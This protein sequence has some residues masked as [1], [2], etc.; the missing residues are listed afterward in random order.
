[1]AGLEK[2]FALHA[3]QD[4]DDM[5]TAIYLARAF[6]GGEHFLRNLRT[7]GH[8]DRVDADIAIAAGIYLLA[9]IGE[10]RPAPAFRGF[11]VPDE[12]IETFVFAALP[13]GA[14][15][16]VFDK[17]PPHADILQPVDHVRL[18]ISPVPA[19]AADF[20]II[21]LYAAGQVDVE[22]EPDVRF[23][24]P[25]AEGD[26]G[27]DDN[28][29]IGHE[30]VLVGLANTRI[31]ARVIGERVDAVVAQILRRFLGFLAGQAIDDAACAP[32]PFEEVDHL[33]LPVLLHLD[34][35]FDIRPVEPEDDRSGVPVEQ[36]GDDI[37]SGHGVG[38]GRQRGNG[39]A[40]K[41]RAKPGEL[42][43]FRPEGRPPLRNAMRFVHGEQPDIEFRQRRQHALCHQ[44]FGRHIQQARLPRRRAAPRCD[45][46]LAAARGIDG[47]GGN[48]RK[49]EGGD[50]VFHQGDQWRDDDGQAAGDQRRYLETERFARSGRHD[51]QDIAA[52]Q[53][54]IDNFFLTRPEG[55]E[56][57]DVLEGRVLGVSRYVSRRVQ[58]FH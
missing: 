10:Q 50:L 56:A 20:L 35:Q 34:R 53:K 57:E 4:I 42:F 38:G 14:G 26:C 39:N 9:E 17:H 48:A 22:D 13:V 58:Y 21:G 43:V 51:G 16:L 30:R 18:G 46:V 8:F 37:V 27:D 41:H 23:V 6:D 1:M 24:D 28:G 40:G 55:I 12:R 54:R 45:I 2:F 47:I 31:H 11:A 44:P 33:A 25:H 36:A 19:R 15:I 29:G 5:R 3:A 52:R 49:F 32:V 7:V